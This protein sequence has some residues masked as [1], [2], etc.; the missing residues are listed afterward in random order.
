MRYEIDKNDLQNDLLVETLQALA[1]CYEQIGAEVY[2]VGA[3]ARDLALRLLKVTNAPRRTMDLDVAVL[4]QDWSQY[5]RLTE[6]LFQNHFV[7]SAAKQRFAY[8][9]NDGKNRYEVDI[10]PFGTIAENEQVAWP[11]EGSPVMS[12]R[13]FDEVMRCADYVQV[14][15]SFAIRIAP[16]SGQFLIKLDAWSDR[17]LTTRKDASD[18]VFILQNV[19]VAYALS[20]TGLP[21][22][23]DIDAEHFDVVV[24]GAEWIVAD[25]KRILSAEHRTYYAQMLQSEVEKE[26]N[27]PLLND[28]LDVSDARNYGLYRR[29]LNRMA[30]ILAS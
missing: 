5:E 30:Q 19:Y 9:G 23:I 15:N 7:K 24:A 29:A 1:A 26:E 6:I 4:L 8:V 20:R 21:E 27:S 2:V 25:L 12:V 14:E 17:H 18:M 22:E 16:L 10:V 13:C 28:M 3:A 11:P